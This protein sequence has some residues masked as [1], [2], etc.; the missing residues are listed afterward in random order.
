MSFSVVFLGT[1][2]F[3]L[4][5]LN[6]LMAHK[7]FEVKGVITQPARQ[8]KRGMHL[9]PSPVQ[10]KAKALSLPV[11]TPSDLKDPDFLSQVQALKAQWAVLL[12]YGKILPPAFLNL[13][14]NKALNFH[15]SLLPR[16]RGAAPVQRAIMAG[17]KT[18]GLSLQ[19]MTQGLDK[20]P[21]TGARSFELTQDMSAHMVFDKMAVLMEDLLT[22]ML[23]YMR[24]QKN[25]LP[26]EEGLATYAPRIDKKETRIIW[27]KPAM[28]LFNQI[29]A[30]DKGPQAWTMLKGKRI[31]IYKAQG[32]LPQTE[33][34]SGRACDKAVMISSNGK[35]QK[36]AQKNTIPEGQVVDI[37]KNQFKVACGNQS[38]LSILTLQPESKNIMSAG[39]YTRGYGLKVGDKFE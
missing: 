14:P 35:T 8:K 30:L 5:C 13:F 24:G 28:T 39:E 16:W 22:D 3:S 4:K 38:V 19:V 11:L 36:P 20:G 6:C 37:Q 2:D 18:L 10:E 17:D 29:R 1:D 31:K 12:S 27:E 32:P 9:L 15:T 23:A 25:P 7:D 34:D 21:V 26:Q 33:L